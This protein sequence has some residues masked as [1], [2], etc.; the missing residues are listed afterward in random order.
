MLNESL[1]RADRDVRAL[2]ILLTRKVMQRGESDLSC[3]DDCRI[4][5]N[6]SLRLVDEKANVVCNGRVKKRNS[7]VMTSVVAIQI[8]VF[9]SFSIDDLV[10]PISHIIVDL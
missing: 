4:A 8:F 3:L 5:E 9:V 1:C 2:S 10:R 6:C 7:N